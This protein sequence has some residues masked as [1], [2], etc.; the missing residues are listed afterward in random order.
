MYIYTH[1]YWFKYF[2]IYIYY[3][4]TSYF[5]DA[6]YCILYTIYCILYTT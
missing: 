3:I 4:S 6:I 2:L 1:I 5:A